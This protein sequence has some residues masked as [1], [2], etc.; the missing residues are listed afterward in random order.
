MELATCD[1]FVA[2]DRQ[3]LHDLSDRVFRVGDELDVFRYLFRL[4]VGLSFI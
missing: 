4:F 1:H 2:V 3:I